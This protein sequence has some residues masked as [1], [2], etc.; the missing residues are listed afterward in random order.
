M[1]WLSLIFPSSLIS[2]LE[3]IWMP[4]LILLNIFKF[5]SGYVIQTLFYFRILLDA[6]YSGN[7]RTVFCPVTHKYW[8]NR[9]FLKQASMYFD[10]VIL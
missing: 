3:I 10:A 8:F 7:S 6:C 9:L 5:L 2:V 4:L 1:E